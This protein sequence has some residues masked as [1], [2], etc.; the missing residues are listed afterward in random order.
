MPRKI[1]KLD[2]PF[3]YCYYTEDGLH[4]DIDAQQT[5]Q[6]LD[7]L[8]EFK[9]YKLTNLSDDLNLTEEGAYLLFDYMYEDEINVP[10]V[11]YAES[12]SGKK[13]F[14]LVESEEE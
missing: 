11:Q 1:I 5:K 13:Y 9:W 14:D 4:P 2:T 10:F 7:Q 12:K 6:F 3:P 8:E